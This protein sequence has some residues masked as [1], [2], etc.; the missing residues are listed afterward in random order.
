MLLLI[1]D[2]S[3]QQPCLFV[4]GIILMRIPLM[5]CY[6]SSC[7]LTFGFKGVGAGYP[8]IFSRTGHSTKRAFIVI[9]FSLSLAI[10]CQHEQNFVDRYDFCRGLSC[11]LH[12]YRKKKGV[13]FA[14]RSQ[15]L[16]FLFR[17]KKG[18]DGVGSQA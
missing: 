15:R 12:P 13:T 8:K 17:K 1:A 6:V 10:T 18:I 16:P 11:Y 4:A 2:L 7:P 3:D 14:A 9:P 5:Y